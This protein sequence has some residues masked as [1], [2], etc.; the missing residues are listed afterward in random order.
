M[1]GD[2]IMVIGDNQDLLKVITDFYNYFSFSTVVLKQ[3]KD[4]K[5]IIRLS[6]DLLL[7]D[8]DLAMLSGPDI[9]RSIRQ[10]Q[11]LTGLPIVIITALNDINFFRNEDIQGA[12]QKPF[13]L[14][15][16]LKITMEILN[17]KRQRFI[18]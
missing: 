6:P 8:L 4:I 16:L 15:N 18:I 2:K 11:Y 5:E 7:L 13:D 14:N 1:P 17:S 12:L 10:N 9:L 3:C